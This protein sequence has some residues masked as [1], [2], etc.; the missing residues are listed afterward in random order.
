MALLNDL[1]DFG[2]LEASKFSLAEEMIGLHELVM[3][4]KG[5]M[6]LLA[7]KKGIQLKFDYL[8]NIPSKSNALKFTKKGY[9]QLTSSCLKKDHKENDGLLYR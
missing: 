5:D 8:E 4:I 1:L 2:K 7:H 3:K 6:L 9:A